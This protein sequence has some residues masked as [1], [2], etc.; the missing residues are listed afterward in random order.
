[1]VRT[2][3]IEICCALALAGCLQSTPNTCANGGACPT[4]YQC[5]NASGAPSCV[6]ATCGDGH[7]DPGETCD[8]GNHVSG[9]GCPSSCGP[10][11]GDGI[12]DP[13]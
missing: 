10:P 6:L 9:D 3:L 8:D 2:L 12:V 4:G 5:T 11:C 1:M 13:G 7:V